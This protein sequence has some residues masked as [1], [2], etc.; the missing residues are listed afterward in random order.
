MKIPPVLGRGQDNADG[1]PNTKDLDMAR[2]ISPGVTT[3]PYITTI[4]T[5]YRSSKHQPVVPVDA[6]H[7]ASSDI[8][9]QTEAYR[10]DGQ[11][12]ELHDGEGVTPRLWVDIVWGRPRGEDLGRGGSHVG[13]DLKKSEVM[14][15]ARRERGTR[16]HEYHGVVAGLAKTTRQD[17]CRLL[18]LHIAG[19]G[20]R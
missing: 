3:S 20:C 1:D 18:A 15:G 11:G 4:M 9:A 8:E 14:V 16:A 6:T 13:E 2:R 12:R 10:A 17:C 5:T 7:D 19:L